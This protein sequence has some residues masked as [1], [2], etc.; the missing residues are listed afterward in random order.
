VPRVI[1]HR[2]TEDHEVVVDDRKVIVLLLAIALVLLGSLAR[3]TL[4]LGI[5]REVVFHHATLLEGVFDQ[6][7]V[8]QAR[9]LEHL[10]KNS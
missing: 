10:I 3:V 2:T 8:V 9:F 1:G 5:P 7:P 6:A 4:P